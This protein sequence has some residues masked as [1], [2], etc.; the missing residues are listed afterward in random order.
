MD[1]SLTTI[2][3]MRLIS[4]GNF[5]LGFCNYDTFKGSRHLRLADWLLISINLCFATTQ[6]LDGSKL[7][8]DSYKHLACT[9]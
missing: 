5:C 7:S 8:N 3:T 6:P 1:I 2:A 9:L 4:S